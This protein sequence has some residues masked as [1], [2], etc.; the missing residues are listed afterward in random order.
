MAPG[1]DPSGAQQQALS[2]VV[3]ACV[4][5]E[6]FATSIATVMTASLPPT[7][8]TRAEAQTAC[9]HDAVLAFDDSERRT[10]Q[11][12]LLTLGGPLDSDLATARNELVNSLYRTCGVSPGS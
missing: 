7:D 3:E 9:L 4:T 5:D 10:L 8:P 11:V 1:V 2:D 6:G 12:G